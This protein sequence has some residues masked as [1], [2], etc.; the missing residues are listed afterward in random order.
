MNI[1]QAG[2]VETPQDDVEV[3]EEEVQNNEGASKEDDC[4]VGRQVTR[5]SS[6]SK[7]KPEIYNP[8]SGKN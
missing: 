6:R 5:K 7:R 8:S 3:P 4:R 1:N 2:Q